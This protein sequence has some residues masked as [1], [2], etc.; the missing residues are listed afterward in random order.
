MA[1]PRA[2]APASSVTTMGFPVTSEMICIQTL[3]LVTPPQPT[4]VLTGL[5]F[6]SKLSMMF[7]VPKATDSSRAL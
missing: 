2:L 5:P 4:M 6:C 1:H 7:F 3:S